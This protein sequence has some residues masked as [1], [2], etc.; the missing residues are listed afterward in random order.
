MPVYLVTA[1]TEPPTEK[2][3][4]APNLASARNYVARQLLTVA[5]AKGPD[6]FRIAKAGGDME[7]AGPTAEPAEAEAAERS[8]APLNIDGEAEQKKK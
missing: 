8:E 5:V 4:D 1:P 7:T 6:L 3:V 2:L